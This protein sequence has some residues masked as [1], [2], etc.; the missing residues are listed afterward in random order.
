MPLNRIFLNRR[1][2]NVAIMTGLL[3][4]LVA[5]AAGGATDVSSAYN[6]RADLQSVADRAALFG[7]RDNERDESEIEEF[8]LNLLAPNYTRNTHTVVI[9]KTE[10]GIEVRIDG[11]SP[12][13]FLGLFGMDDLTVNVDARAANIAG[14]VENIEVALVLDT[15]ESMVDDMDDLRQAALDL[16][17]TLYEAG[18]DDEER[19][20][21]SVVPYAGTVNIGKDAPM[22]WMDAG[23]G[24]KWH[25]ESI[26]GVRVKY[27]EA[28]PPDPTTSTTP[29]T[30][31]PPSS[32]PSCTK[33]CG[34]PGK[35]ACGGGGDGASLELLNGLRYASTPILERIAA[36]MTPT[37]AHAASHNYPTPGA[38]ECPWR[39]PEQINNFDLFDAVP[40]TDW[41]G[42]VEVRPEPFDVTDTPPGSDPNTQFVPFFWYDDADNY[43][44]TMPW[45]N[46]YLDDDI[47]LEIEAPA[48]LDTWETAMRSSIYK[49]DGYTVSTK[50]DESGSNIIGPNRGCPAPL[51]P[52]TTERD[53]IMD[54]IAGLTHREGGGTAIP[55][56]LAWGWR[57]LSPGAPFTEGV[58][59]DEPET[60]K[61]IL[62]LTDGANAV[63]KRGEDSDGVP[64]D[65]DVYGDMTAYGYASSFGKG[66]LSRHYIDPESDPGTPYFEQIRNYL[67]ARTRTVCEN[68]KNA[69]DEN[70]IEIF[71]VLI[72][73]HDS[74]TEALLS[75]CATSEV[76][77]YHNAAQITQLSEAF[78]E[79]AGEI[80]G[81][82]RARITH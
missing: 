39:T 70:P 74:R 45:L 57:T 64:I 16:V 46:N 53:E 20:K 13:K 19:V 79:V 43:D 71:T 32:T 4:G 8:A 75:D 34:C 40:N 33:V 82:G 14:L 26:E 56:G 62:L 55:V 78:G 27:C 2:G 22:A 37:A 15:T 76:T 31:T 80:I 35:V 30:S 18:N 10:D 47:G 44:S 24:S 58:A 60:K 38:A 29:T 5:M 51:L 69:D 61:I 17:E 1:D 48:K 12:N 63:L 72:G 25:A 65:E 73:D 23:G 66:W 49:Y 42:C 28:P 3:F 21:I 7:A 77:H 36:L 11:N 52:L 59:Y 6:Y 81:S 68:I 67:D 50:I 54:K 9:D 41:M